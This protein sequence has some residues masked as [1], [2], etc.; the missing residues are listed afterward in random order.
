MTGCQQGEATITSMPSRP[1]R[2]EL[3]SGLIDGVDKLNAATL[4]GD[5]DSARLCLT[6]LRELSAKPGLESLAAALAGL[7][8][9]FG[10]P[11]SEPRTGVGRAL[12]DV[13]H[14]LES[15]GRD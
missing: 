4:D 1:H 9:V 12:V 11:G 5:F 14:A 8:N 2:I 3:P 6:H 10:L 13:T 15:L 7:S